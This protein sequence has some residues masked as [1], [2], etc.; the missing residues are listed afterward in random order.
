MRSQLLLVGSVKYANSPGNGDA[1][2]IEFGENRLAIV[3]GI[4]D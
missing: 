2:I 4:G 3:V 1:L